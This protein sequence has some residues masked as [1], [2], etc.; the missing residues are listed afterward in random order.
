[1]K[2][3]ALIDFVEALTVEDP[4]G[5]SRVAGFWRQCVCV[6]EWVGASR[7]TLWN[8]AAHAL[9]QLVGYKSLF[10]KACCGSADCF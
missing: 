6:Q 2:T 7:I 8:R 4:A 1:M 3:A 5:V 9:P 10:D